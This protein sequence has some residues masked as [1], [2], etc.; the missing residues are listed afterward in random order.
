MVASPTSD[1]RAWNVGYLG[2]E[3]K[4]DHQDD[5]SYFQRNPDVAIPGGE[6]LHAFRARVRPPI[7][8]AIHRG[9]ETGI[10]SIVVAHSSII[11]ELGN[12][13]HG[14]HTKGLVRPG[15]VT[16]VSFDGKYFKTIPLVGGNGHG[17]GYGS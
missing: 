8:N 15:G 3:I 17:E 16:G 13:I 6:S 5:I 10:P 4:A 9:V 1:L 11:H 2:G 14:D 7:L 12:L